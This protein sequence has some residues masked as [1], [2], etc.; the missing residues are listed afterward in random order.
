MIIDHQLVAVAGGCCPFFVHSLT[1][2]HKKH[3]VLPRLA[4][5]SLIDSRSTCYLFEKYKK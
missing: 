1:F 2:L 4:V 3:A 5:E